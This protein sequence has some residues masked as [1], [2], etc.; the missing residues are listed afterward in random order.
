MLILT[1]TLNTAITISVGFGIGILVNAGV[2][3]RFG[4]TIGLKI[5]NL[6]YGTV[7]TYVKN[8]II[9]HQILIQIAKSQKLLGS[10]SGK[11]RM[12]ATIKA[13]QTFIPG[14]LDDAIVQDIIQSIYDE[15]IK[16]VK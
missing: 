7:K 9:R 14:K 1:D 12:E 5:K 15:L 10:E 2:F 4:S 6:I 8:P 13:V 3:R 11:K 16:E